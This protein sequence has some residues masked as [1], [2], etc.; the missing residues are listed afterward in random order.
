MSNFAKS[1]GPGKYGLSQNTRP[2]GRP[3]H[4]RSKSQAPARPRTAHGSRDDERFE[5]SP[6]NGTETFSSRD[7]AFS[8]DSQHYHKVRAAQSI[9]TS[10]K[11]RDSSLTTRF[12]QLSL[13]DD[14]STLIGSQ[15]T[16]QPPSGK[17]S[18]SSI[19]S[20]LSNVSFKRRGRD[21]SNHEP[22]AAASRA[23]SEKA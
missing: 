21:K 2:Q 4:A 8:F 13:E 3:G 10:L 12:N 11:N 14:R 1:V 18:D 6:S 15:A 22:V 16:S 9:S 19:A 23:S 20:Q 5:T 7:D 17:N